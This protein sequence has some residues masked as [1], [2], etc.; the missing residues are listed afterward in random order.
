MKRF[1]FLVAVAALMSSVASTLPARAAT[2]VDRLMENSRFCDTSRQFRNGPASVDGPSSQLN[3]HNDVFEP[4]FAKA[5]RI[6]SGLITYLGTGDQAGINAVLDRRAERAFGTADIP[7]SPVEM[8]QAYFDTRA[9]DRRGRYTAIHQIPLMVSVFGVAYNLPS[10]K[11]PALNLR[12]TVLSAIFNG[13]IASWDDRLLVRDNPGLAGCRLP[14]RLIKRAD[15][16]GSTAI[17]K[18]YL[19]KRNPQW[20]HYK[21]PAQNLSWPTLANTCPALDEDGMADCIASTSN[22]IGYLSLRTA[23]LARLK[24]ARLDNV[25]SQTEIDPEKAFIAP[26]PEACTEAARS[27]FIPPGVEKQQV[28]PVPFYEYETNSVSPTRGDWSTVSLTD[29]PRGY[30]MCSFGYAFIYISLQIAYF[31]QQYLPNTARTAVD[32][33]YTAVTPQAQRRLPPFG[34]GA[35]PDNV[36]KISILGLSEI[37]F[38]S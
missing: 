34:Y 32:Y 18:D 2:P 23:K 14:I 28:R 9:P 21:Q 6:G 37:R 38:Q 11:V 16:A 26:S 19:A 4:A 1:R 27:A 30:P 24:M 12:S 10:C 31:G 15:F 36:A 7:L 33:L 5:C 20:T 8:A 29:A 13:T 17:F 3:V 35:L 25:Q 22:S